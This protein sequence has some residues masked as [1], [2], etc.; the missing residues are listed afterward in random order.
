MSPQP[1]LPSQQPISFP[2]HI[3]H[4]S[5]K[6]LNSLRIQKSREL[7]RKKR[8]KNKEQWKK[9]KLKNGKQAVYKEVW[10]ILVKNIPPH[11][12]PNHTTEALLYKSTWDCNRNWNGDMGG[13]RNEN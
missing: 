4:F 1:S 6:V 11:I 12:Q 10:S 13:G 9:I 8:H 3:F 2:C 5:N 7:V